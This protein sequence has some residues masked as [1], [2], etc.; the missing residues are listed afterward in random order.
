MKTLNPLKILFLILIVVMSCSKDDNNIDDVI[1]PSVKGILTIKGVEYELVNG[2]IHDRGKQGSLSV[3][4]FDIDLLSSGLDP[5][6]Q[7]GIGTIVAMEMFTET[8]D[9]LKEGTYILDTNET[10]SAGTFGGNILLGYNAETDEST[11]WFIPTS[12]IIVFSKSGSAYDFI[13]DFEAD[14]ITLNDD[15]DIIII[16]SNVVISCNYNGS[17]IHN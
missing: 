17:L 1:I 5:I 2:I 3:Y 10:Y 8:A 14:E 7:K 11:N 4:N 13:M 9:D 12:G 15:W 16:D 6:T